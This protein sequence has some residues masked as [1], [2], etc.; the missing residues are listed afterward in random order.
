MPIGI[1]NAQ[2]DHNLECQSLGVP[3]LHCSKPVDEWIQQVNAIRQTTNWHKKA[4]RE[5]ALEKEI[6]GQ[7]KKVK[8][9]IYIQNIAKWSII[10]PC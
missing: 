6:S 9:Q 1:P 5:K 7:D 10:A 2:A 4:R 3:V 8:E